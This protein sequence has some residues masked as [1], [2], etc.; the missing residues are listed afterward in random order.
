M[1]RHAGPVFL[2]Q[3]LLIGLLFKAVNKESI[4]FFKM[5]SKVTKEYAES[6]GF[7]A[8]FNTTNTTN[9]HFSLFATPELT[10]AWEAGKRR[11]AYAKKKALMKSAAH[12]N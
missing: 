12:R 9:C 10:K 7:D 2:L 11:G 3:S 1:N 6:M 5:P 8:E 4:M